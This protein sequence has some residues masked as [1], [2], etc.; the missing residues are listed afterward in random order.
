MTGDNVCA[1]ALVDVDGDS[2]PEL[3]VGMADFRLRVLRHDG[4]LLFEL[5]QTEVSRAKRK[6]KK[7]RKRKRKK[8]G[9]GR[10]SGEKYSFQK[11]GKKAYVVGPFL[12]VVFLSKRP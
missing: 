8:K 9:K 12:C 4:E 2:Q 7:K 10:E 11:K 5:S 3:V 6:K 1:L